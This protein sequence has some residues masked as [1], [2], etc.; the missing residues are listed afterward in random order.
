MEI[1]M[2]ITMN[3]EQEIWVHIKSERARA[4]FRLLGLPDEEH[5]IMIGMPI[6]QFIDMLPP[7]MVYQIVADKKD[8]H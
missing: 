5:S 3:E 4:E 1:D 6:D 8:L 7:D 2:L